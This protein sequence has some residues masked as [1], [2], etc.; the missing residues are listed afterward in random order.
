MWQL[1]KEFLGTKNNTYLDTACHGLVAQSTLQKINTE[2]LEVMA[3]APS[4]SATQDTVILRK[5]FEQA[6]NNLQQ[7]LK[8]QA[9]EIAITENA[10]SALIAIFKALNLKRD[11][12]VLCCEM[13]FFGLITPLK[14]WGQPLRFFKQVAGQICLGE[15]EKKIT[16]KSKVLLVSAV[17]E[18]TGYQADLKALSQFCQS[19]QLELIVDATQMAGSQPLYP[20]QVALD[21][22]FS[23]GFK[24]LTNPFATGFLYINKQR[25]KDLTAGDW[26]YFNLSEPVEGWEA[27]LASQ[28]KTANYQGDLIKK[29][30]RFENGGSGNYGGA[31]GLANAVELLNKAGIEEVSKHNQSLINYLKAN[32][33][34]LTIKTFDFASANVSNILVLFYEQQDKTKKL[35]QYLLAEKIKTS[36]RYNSKVGGLRISPHFYNHQLDIQNLIA[37]ITAF[38]KN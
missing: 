27:F 28:D 31:F 2:F 6:R 11:A 19:H 22:V 18:V 5:G 30:A 14:R 24:W 38:E 12:E 21:F 34:H 23:S 3:L 8:C 15:I 17:Q 13:D 1:R 33:K 32:L 4:K 36:L 7:L 29:A 10:T 20:D 35:Y 37:A 16:P 9:E 26:G 25:L